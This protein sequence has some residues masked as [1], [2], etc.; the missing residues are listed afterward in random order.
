MRRVFQPGKYPLL[1]MNGILQ[2]ARMMNGIGVDR[3][4]KWGTSYRQTL[5]TPLWP[6]PVYD[7]FLAKG[8]L[9]VDTPGYANVRSWVDLAMISM[10]RKCS[11]GTCEHCSERYNLGR[12]DV[13]PV[14]KLMETVDYLQERGAGVIAFTGGEPLDE[15]AR[16]LTLLEHGDKTKSEFRLYTTGK[17]LTPELAKDLA[18]AGLSSVLISIDGFDAETYDSFRRKSGVFDQAVNA[19]KLFMDAGVFVFGNVTLSRDLV[20]GEGLQK[21]WELLRDLNVPAV[22]MIEPKTCGGYFKDSPDDLFRPEDIQRTR[23]IVREI[24]K[25]PGDGPVIY[26]VD[27]EER[28]IGCRAGGMLLFHVDSVG[29][30]QPCVFLPISFGNILEEDFGTI[31][32]RMR[33]ISPDATH[34]GCMTGV[35]TPALQSLYKQGVKVPIPVEKVKAEYERLYGI[36]WDDGEEWITEARRKTKGKNQPSPEKEEEKELVEV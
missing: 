24:R 1:K 22:Q 6:S 13:V 35:L 19:M 7:R 12:E 34:E 32:E 29:N 3:W 8:G 20:Q 27:E 28:A 11:I 26:W 10:T 36:E 16:L 21:L 4:I 23:E 33:K 31:F 18:A 9:N 30:V 2:A 15:P 14:E 5:V 17:G 25:D